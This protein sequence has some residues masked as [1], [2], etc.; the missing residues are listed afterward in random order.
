MIEARVLTEKLASIG[1]GVFAGLPCSYLTPLINTVIADPDID[2]V[3]VANEGDAVAVASGAA[4]GGKLGVVLFQNSGLGNAVSPLT[5]LT[6]TFRIPL[7]V[8]VTWRGQPGGPADEPQHG[9]MG[10][11]T[12]QLLELMEIPWET[13]PSEE[14]RLDEVLARVAAAMREGRPYALIVE[15]GSIAGDASPG[16]HA[17]NASRSPHTPVPR[18]GVPLDPDD[19]LR[20][21]QSG[22][23]ERDAVLATTGFTGRALEA[24]DDRPSQL[25]MVGSM[26]CASSLGL[27][28]A[29]AQPS[30][31]VVVLDGDGAL[32]MRMGAL[33]TIGFEQTPNL[34][35]IVLD[36]GVHDSTG[37]QA[38]VSPSVD[39]PG[40][41]HASG[42]PRVH[43]VG[44]LAEL[45]EALESGPPEL[46]FL[47][48]RTLP[49]AD[50]K[51]P[52][53]KLAPP[54]VAERFRTWLA[55]QPA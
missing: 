45:S 3:G 16:H 36:N 42:Y 46:T 35:H 29:K 13:L 37:A 21:I 49:R 4:L 2:Y 14:S 12:P 15:K 27:G 28:L 39:L 1:F 25:Y 23:A 5:S 20:T 33:A 31:R 44:S 10:S 17:A 41:A 9:L 40:L 24:L 30:R 55:D 8:L 32:L 38:T 51:L 26:G 18:D 19:V 47:H 6:A 54:Q 34:L 11:I 48:V 53:P 52:R 43:S 7:L 50:R 22:L